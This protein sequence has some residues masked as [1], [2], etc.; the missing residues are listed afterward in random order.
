MWSVTYYSKT[1]KSQAGMSLVEVL[2]SLGITVILMSAT[3]SMF[4]TQHRENRALNQKLEFLDLKNQVM[5]A[6]QNLN[7]CS[8]HL[9]GK[10]FD[11]TG[12]TTT[13]P[14]STTINL[15]ALYQAANS[16][17]LV[18]ARENSRLPGTVTNLEV[19]TIQFKNITATGNSNEFKGFF[20]VAFSNS[21]LARSMRPVQIPQTIQTTGSGTATIST[22]GSSPS[23]GG[24]TLSS[25]VLSLD[26]ITIVRGPNKN[27]HYSPSVARCP[28]GYAA[29][30]GSSNYVTTSGCKDEWVGQSVP[31]EDKQ[32]WQ[33]WMECAVHYTMAVCVRLKQ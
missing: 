11:T 22:C 33:G 20:E 1:K 31:T 30:A 14:S 25:G 2:V 32:G 23:S 6:F 7:T 3:A 17:S 26:D 9:A 16:T 10:T 28:S 8:W 15:T 18:L 19:S 24:G 27:R 4:L 13:N 29:I 5:Q 12:V 21:S